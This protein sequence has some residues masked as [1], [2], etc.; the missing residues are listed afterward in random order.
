MTG[1]RD[2]F[3]DRMFVILGGRTSPAPGNDFDL[4]SLIVTERD[5]EPGMQS[6]HAAILD[7]CRRPTA[8]VEIAAKLR[9][10][11][12]FVKILLSTLLD[13]R[14]ISARHPL[15]ATT[16]TA[17]RPA[18]DAGRSRLPSRAR[19]PDRNLVEKVLSGLRNL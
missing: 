16:P 4:V 17:R 7:L 18:A 8:V 14:R 2:D 9:M 15:P 5:S 12:G 10:P 11:V 13:E 1:D 19:I 6:E 3:P